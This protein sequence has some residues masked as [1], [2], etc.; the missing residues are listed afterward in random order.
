MPATVFAFTVGLTLY[1][2]QG[3]VKLVNLA[4]N[5]DLIL[6][7]GNIVLDK[8]FLKSNDEIQVAGKKFTWMSEG[9]C[10]VNKKNQKFLLKNQFQL[11]PA[12][13]GLDQLFNTK[14]DVVL[15]I[16]CLQW[17]VTSEKDSPL[18]GMVVKFMFWKIIIIVFIFLVLG[19]LKRILS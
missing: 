10:V 11:N 12:P 17:P 7:N 9:E 3:R 18:Q 1:F 19:K 5:K 13:P 16:R 8:C 6:V 15:S 4:S 14:K 2:F